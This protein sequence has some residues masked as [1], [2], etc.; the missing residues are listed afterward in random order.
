M[1]TTHDAGRLNMVE[2]ITD[3]TAQHHPEAAPQNKELLA[4]ELMKRIDT[5][6]ELPTLSTVVVQVLS[7]LQDI[8]TSAEE[9]TKVVEKDQAIVPKLLKLVNSAFFGFSTKVT[10]VQHAVM[11]LGFNTVRNAVLSVEVINALELKRRIE[12]FDIA[13]FWRHAIT[14]AVISRYLDHETGKQYRE[15]VFAAGLIHDI[16]KIVMAHYFTDRFEA[17]WKTMCKE[18][19]TFWEAEPEHFPINHAAIGA[20][21]ALRWNLPPALKEVVANHHACDPGGDDSN[22]VLI[23]HTADALANRFF[24]EEISVEEWPISLAAME[25]MAKQIN[26]AEQWMPDLKEEIASACEVLIKE[27]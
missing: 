7:M 4:K 15:D 17:T 11:L 16:G 1:M 26:S 18:K 20:Q 14:V 25:F 8:N 27:G 10:S 9:L 24:E 12:G 22:L 13:R 21:L 19:I 6:Q 23:V 5:I 3:T 2:D